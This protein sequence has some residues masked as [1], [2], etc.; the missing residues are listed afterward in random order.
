MTEYTVEIMPEAI[1]DLQC[2]YDYIAYSLKSKT[3]AS[4]QLDRLE[5]EISGLA[6]LPEGFRLYEKEPW[7]SRGLRMFPVDN[8]IIFYI[9]D[10]ETKTVHVLRVMYGKMNFPDMWN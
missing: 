2:I 3:N 10:T 4:A 1:D 7:H 8:Y 9:V 5:A 6:Y